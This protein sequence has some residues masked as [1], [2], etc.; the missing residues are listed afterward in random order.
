MISASYSQIVLF[1]DFDGMLKR[2][3]IFIFIFTKN[4]FL[5][6]VYI[7]ASFFV[8]ALDRNRPLVA[9]YP[10]ERGGAKALIGVVAPLEAALYNAA[11]PQAPARREPGPFP[12]PHAYL[13]R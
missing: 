10:T 2:F 5:F 11:A 4:A 7:F 1:F 9:L 8:L 6:F 13:I 3:F 12:V